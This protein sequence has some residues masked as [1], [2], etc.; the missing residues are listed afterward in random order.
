LMCINN[1]YRFGSWLLRFSGDY[2]CTN[3]VKS[4]TFWILS[5]CS[6]G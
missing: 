3:T 1:T 4:S 5:R 6:G 2:H